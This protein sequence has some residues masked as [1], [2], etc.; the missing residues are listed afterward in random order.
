MASLLR[1]PQLHV[2]MLRSL[3]HLHQLSIRLLGQEFCSIV[4]DFIV[5]E[6]AEYCLDGNNF[7]SAKRIHPAATSFRCLELQFHS[8]FVERIVA[9]FIQP[10]LDAGPLDHQLNAATFDH[11]DV[12]SRLKIAD[13]WTNV[14]NTFAR[15]EACADKALDFIHFQQHGQRFSKADCYCIAIIVGD[16]M[17]RALYNLACIIDGPTELLGLG[18]MSSRDLFIEC[19]HVEPTRSNAWHNLACDLQVRE[20]VALKDGTLVDDAECFR[21]ALCGTPSDPAAWLSVMHHYHWAH[22]M[23]YIRLDRVE[24]NGRQYSYL[25]CAVE[26]LALQPLTAEAWASIGDYLAKAP[27]RTSHFAFKG[28]RYDAAQSYAMFFVVGDIVQEDSEFGGRLHL[29][30]VISYRL[31]A[32]MNAGDGGPVNVDGALVA[33]SGEYEMK[34]HRANFQPPWSIEDALRALRPLVRLLP[35]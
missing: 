5:E 4:Q 16:K 26:A 1:H 13:V 12:K 6:M 21:R 25:E 20:E 30:K 14:G 15:I 8:A 10:V 11:L 33:K 2:V 17:A 27:D 18:I 35:G 23:R 3:E 34:V 32:I 19:L 9:P 28:R 22:F 29:Q 7:V 24:V 31:L